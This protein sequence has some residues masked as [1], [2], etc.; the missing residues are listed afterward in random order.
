MKKLHSLA[1]LMGITILGITGFQLY[2]L[3]ENYNREEKTVA[4]KSE[5]AF[6]KTMEQL[7]VTKLKLEGFRL[8]R[9][10]KAK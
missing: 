5:V 1:I 9:P 2:W 8:T 6:R 10:I 4:I 3:K 7:Q